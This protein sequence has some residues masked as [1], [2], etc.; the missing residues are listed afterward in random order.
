MDVASLPIHS[1]EAQK[2]HSLDKKIILEGSVVAV[3]DLGTV[4]CEKAILFMENPSKG[5]DIVS[6]TIEMENNVLID[7][8]DGSHLAANRGVIDCVKRE[9]I[10]YASPQEKVV[11]DTLLDEKDPTSHV[12]ATSSIL[13]GRLVKKEDGWKLDD[14][15]AEGSVRIEYKDKNK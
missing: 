8:S 15:H 14:L 13:K 10:F 1:V 11:Y 2:V 12:R 6:R 5:N 3:L 7:F 9:G 4:T